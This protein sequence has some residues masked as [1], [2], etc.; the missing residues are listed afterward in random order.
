MLK[1]NMG[2]GHNRVEGFVNVDA[3][4]QSA[5]DQIWDLERTPWPWPDDCASEIRFIHSLEHMGQRTDVFLSM[6][7]ELYRVC[8]NGAEIRIHVPHPR[9]DSFVGDPTHVRAITPLTLS[10]FDKTLNDQWKAA[11]SANTPLAHYLNVDF[12]VKGRTIVLD[13]DIRAE[14]DAGRL[15]R[16]DVVRLERTQFNVVAELQFVLTAHKPPRGP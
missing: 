9:H 4:T 16:E 13:P 12:E 1:L 8:A 10:L 3:A 15:S 7:K 14:F 5:A 11:G 2:C 6:M